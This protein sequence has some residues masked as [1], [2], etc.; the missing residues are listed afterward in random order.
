MRQGITRSVQRV[1]ND[2]RALLQPDH[3]GFDRFLRLC[4]RSFLGAGRG[5]RR[6]LGDHRRNDGRLRLASLRPHGCR[7]GR[8][9]FGGLQ[10]ARSSRHDDFFRFKDLRPPI[11]EHERQGRQSF[12]EGIETAVVSGWS[13]LKLGRR[14]RRHHRRWRSLRNGRWRL[15]SLRRR[16]SSPGNDGRRRPGCCQQFLHLA[17][18]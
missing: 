8:D 3:F 9:R 1:A 11:P 17:H 7:C 12:G 5:L 2:R 4:G 10:R 15:V 18:G 6:I 13:F 14:L 16:V